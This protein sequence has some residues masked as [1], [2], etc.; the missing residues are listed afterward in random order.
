M[1]N[2]IPTKSY[3]KQTPIPLY[4]LNAAQ[5]WMNSPGNTDKLHKANDDFFESYNNF[6]TNYSRFMVTDSNPIL[7]RSYIGVVSS[8]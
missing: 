5:Q 4:D 3:I 8:S 2:N 7:T 6:K 1:G